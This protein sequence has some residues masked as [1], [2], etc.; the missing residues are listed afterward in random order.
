MKTRITKLIVLGLSLALVNSASA[1]DD[2][3]DELRRLQ[4]HLNSRQLSALRAGSYGHSYRFRADDDDD[5]DGY[6]RRATY[7]ASPRYG[8]NYG[9]PGRSFSLS[10]GVGNSG[11][12]RGYGY[13]VVARQP[14]LTAPQ[15]APVPTVPQLPP[16]PQYRQPLPAPGPALTAPQGFDPFAYEFGQIMDCPVPLYTNVLVKDR[17]NIAPNAVPIV[18]CARDPNCT[19]GSR[20][21]VQIFVPPCPPRKVRCYNGGRN[22]DYVYPGYEVNVRSRAGKIIVDYDD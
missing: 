16:V 21:F 13:P 17:C 4:R 19:R 15:V 20:V 2:H 9:S 3:R 10:I 12:H 7:R 6:R 5:D 18:V 1:D 11:L 14:I 22:I 8:Y